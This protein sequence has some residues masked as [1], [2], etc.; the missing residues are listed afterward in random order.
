V[1][2][3][4]PP[5]VTSINTKFF[6]DLQGNQTCQVL[7]IYSGTTCPQAGNTNLLQS[8]SYDYKN[9]MTAST[10]YSQGVMTDTA[11]YTL[12]ALDRTVIETEQHS[13]SSGPTTTTNTLYQGDSTA[14]AQETLTGSQADI[15]TYAYDA[16]GSSI[17][18]S[19]AAAGARYSYLYD[20]G[21]SVSML[22]D[23]SGNAKESY[24]YKAYGSSNAALSKKASGFSTG[25]VPTNPVRFQG[26][27]FDSGSGSYDMG[28]RRYSASTG[29]WF[30]QDPDHVRNV[31]LS[32]GPR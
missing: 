25:S 29:R 13:G 1:D 19:D 15:K 30:S 22:L 7:S 17:T 24:G 14:V 3:T 9:R 5:V 6:Y 27:H 21:N 4:N 28:A 23:S 32:L 26:K 18:L 31:D 10:T 12:D 2:T 20:P 8:N 16:F 11:S